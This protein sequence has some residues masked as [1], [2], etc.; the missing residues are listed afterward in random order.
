MSEIHKLQSQANATFTEI[1]NQHVPDSFGNDDRAFS[2]A[3]ESVILCDRSHWGYLEL[4][5]GD[6]LRYLHNQ[7][8]NDFYRLQS[9][10]GCETVFTTSTGRTI[11][12]AT[13]FLTEDSVYLLV[14]PNR[15]QKMME[16][17]D[18]YI[19]PADKVVL[20]DLSPNTAILSL[21]GAQSEALLTQLGVTVLSQNLGDHNVAA[22]ADIT[23]RIAT[24]NGLALPGYT[25]IL[26]RAEA[27]A[28]W[29]TLTQQGAIP[30]GETVWQKLRIEQGRPQPDQE[31]TEEYNPLEA[32]LWQTISFEKGCYIGQE[33]IARLNTYNGVKQELWGIRLSGEVPIESEVRLEGEKVGKLTSISQT[34]TGW[35]GLVYIRTKAGGVGLN[36][37]VGD[38]QGEVVPVPYLT[39]STRLIDP[40]KSEDSA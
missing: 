24:G 5:G 22:I 30:A 8:T 39:Y 20:K 11:D 15:R 9:G 31:L 36:V 23:V 32:R 6:R 38:Q 40:G 19:F 1:L 10:Q 27:G 4:S 26:D 35:I 2:A 17:L 7:S 13:A 37:T 3:F 33:T 18:R 16:W 25:L 21:I 12:L 28:V 34:P 14:S 29:N